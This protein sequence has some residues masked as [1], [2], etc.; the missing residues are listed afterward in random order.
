MKKMK[1]TA[2]FL[3]T[4]LCVSALAGCS[5]GDT[6]NT[7]NWIT[8]ATYGSRSLL[9]NL[10]TREWDDELLGIFE[11][12]REKLCDIAE[13]GSIVGTVTSEAAEKTG[14]PEGIPVISA[15]GDQQ[16][17][18]LGLG[19]LKEG[20]MEVSVGTGGYII[21]ASDGIPD[22]LRQDVICNASAIPGQYILESS[23]LTC[24]S[25]FNWFLK[26]C[27]DMNETNKK[28]VLARVNEDIEKSME[29]DTD[30]IVLPYFQGRG[31]PDWNSRAKGS[32]HNLTLGTT[33][34]DIARA[35]FEGLCIEISDNVNVIEQYVKKTESIFACGGLANS[36]CFTQMLSDACETPVGIYDDN[37]ATALGAWISAAVS[38]GL[39]PDYK[40]A[41]E[42]AR[43]NSQVRRQFVEASKVPYYRSKKQDGAVGGTSSEA[44]ERYQSVYHDERNQPFQGTGDCVKR[45]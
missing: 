27:Y 8:D 9:M 30:V 6:A 34:G 15:G 35:L 40:E 44:L 11:V 12:D 21:A 28:E 7:G 33:R 29:K 31:T 23:I 17:A 13:P 45:N 16:S 14:L 43:Q 4:T 39:Y 2:L 36:A 19:V 20:T 22:D 37:E 1:M 5:G 26:L 41:F 3:S 25:A 24:A 42:Q 10:K 32:F 38:T 18:A